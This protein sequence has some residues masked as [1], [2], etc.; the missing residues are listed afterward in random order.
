MLGICTEGQEPFIMM[1]YMEKG[2]PSSGFTKLDTP[3]DKEI[4][5]KSLIV[6]CTQIAT[7]IEYLA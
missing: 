1:D 7:G 2:D 4:T 5:L 6:F 3:G